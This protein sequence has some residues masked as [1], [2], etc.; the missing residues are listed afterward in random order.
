MLCG[1][2]RWLYELFAQ[3]TTH[4]LMPLEDVRNRD[5][6]EHVQYGPEDRSLC[7]YSVCWT[8]F[9]AHEHL[10]ALLV[11]SS[12]CSAA[13][14]SCCSARDFCSRNSCASSGVRWAQGIS[15]ST[16]SMWYRCVE[17]RQR[18]GEEVDR[19]FR[20]QRQLISNV[21]DLRRHLGRDLL[22]QSSLPG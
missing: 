3:Y 6:L 15:P 22:V 11:H 16:P 20:R 10:F 5:N 14:Y 12:L 21:S 4:R 17:K 9:V 2:E 8:E 18:L 1:S 19:S 13:P 7:A